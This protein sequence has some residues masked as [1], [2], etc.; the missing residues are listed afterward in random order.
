MLFSSAY[1]QAAGSI[2]GFD[3]STIGSMLPVV[4]IF[5]AMYFLMIRPQQKQLKE[6]RAVLDR[7]KK[8]DQ[9]VS[10]GGMIGKI[11]SLSADGREVQLEISP[12]VKVRL[13]KSSIQSVHAPAP[14]PAEPPASKPED[15]AGEDV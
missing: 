14:A 15:K 4:L 7:L 6:H 1:A 13:L 2:G 9:V 3:L 12:G 8:G 10:Q 11:A 5:V